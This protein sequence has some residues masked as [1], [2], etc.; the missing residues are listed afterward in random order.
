MQQQV[1]GVE[2]ENDNAVETHDHSFEQVLSLLASLV[3]QYLLYWYKS[4]NTDT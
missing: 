2:A 4:T 3:K 1:E